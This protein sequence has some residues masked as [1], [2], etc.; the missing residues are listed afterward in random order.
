MS[1]T[2]PEP[3]RFLREPEVRHIT[4]LSRTTRWRLQRDGK[5]P[6]RRQISTNAVGW[7]ASEINVWMAEQSAP[8]EPEAA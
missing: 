3:D 7:L 8:V 5:F 6:R 2:T 1:T 4:G